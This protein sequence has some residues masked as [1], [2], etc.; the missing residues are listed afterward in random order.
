MGLP[1]GAEVV[2]QDEARKKV[3]AAKADDAEWKGATNGIENAEPG[4]PGV[5]F[6]TR[7]G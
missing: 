7:L 6:W 3:A 4:N 5:H 2:S 1:G